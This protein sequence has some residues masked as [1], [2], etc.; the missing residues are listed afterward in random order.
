MVI[1]IIQARLGSTRL[2]NK[3]LKEVVPGISML[4]M[5]ARKV[6]LATSIGHFVTTTPDEKICSLIRYFGGDYSHWTGKRDLISEYYYALKPQSIYRD[7]DAY[8]RI[9]ADCPLL[10]PEEIDRC[11]K[12]FLDSHVDLVC[13]TDYERGNMAGDGNDV[14]V[15]SMAALRQAHKNATQREHVT[16]WMRQNLKVKF[17]QAPDVGCSVDTAE[18]LQHVKDILRGRNEMPAC[19]CIQTDQA[20]VGR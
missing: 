2:P 9:T 17:S 5:V 7:I 19:Q 4:E 10:Q 8:V 18:D 6:Q 16:S 1:A 15:F 20:Q 13:N 14:E 12:L 11:V 3:V